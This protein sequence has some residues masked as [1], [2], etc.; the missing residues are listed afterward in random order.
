LQETGFIGDNEGGAANF[1][2]PFTPKIGEES[3]YGLAR[4]ADGVRNLFV[5]K[6]QYCAGLVVARSMVGGKIQ[7]V[8]GQLFFHRSRKSQT[9]NFPIS[10]VVDI[11]QSLCDSKRDFTVRTQKLQERFPR[12]EVR[13]DRLLRFGRSAMRKINDLPLSEP[14]DNFTRPLQITKTPRGS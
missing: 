7:Q 9:A 3:S 2:E 12:N 4:G 8:T 6:S 13:L 11:G 1:D 14:A 5:R 10:C